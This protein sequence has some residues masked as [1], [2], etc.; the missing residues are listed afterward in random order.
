LQTL[1]VGLLGIGVLLEVC[2][3]YLLQI[4]WEGEDEVRGGGGDGSAEVLGGS[5]NSSALCSRY[6][7]YLLAHRP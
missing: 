4:V 5:A 3:D 2:V 6:Q 1:G 7:V